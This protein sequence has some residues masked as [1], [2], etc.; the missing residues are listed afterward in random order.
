MWGLFDDREVR[1]GIEFD[2]WPPHL[3]E[4]LRPR[5]AF[6]AATYGAAEGPVQD[7]LVQEAQAMPGAS[8]L[9]PQDSRRLAGY[10]LAQALPGPAPGLLGGA[11]FGPQRADHFQDWPTGPYRRCQWN[12]L[13]LVV[14][15]GESECRI[16]DSA[17]SGDDALGE[18]LGR[19]LTECGWTGDDL[20]QATAGRAPLLT[21][22][23]VGG[24]LIKVHESGRAWLVELRS[25]GTCTE[26]PLDE[27]DGDTWAGEW[28]CDAY[29]QLVLAFGGYQL[30]VVGARDGLCPGL[31]LNAAAPDFAES[32]A[33]AR[34]RFIVGAIDEVGDS[35]RAVKW[36]GSKHVFRLTRAAG[37]SWSED[38]PLDESFLFSGAGWGST[39][40]WVV[41]RENANPAGFDLRVESDHG[42]DYWARLTAQRPDRALWRGTERWR[43]A[44]QEDEGEQA[45][46]IAAVRAWPV[47]GWFRHPD[48]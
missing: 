2:V 38:G 18:V 27:D 17:L 42:V 22:P 40:T 8:E 26:T 23:L 16:C 47:G 34:S 39:G 9:T 33:V 30:A 6:L 41:L 21:G 19:E 10:L 36:L 3:V 25:D 1:V 32:G 43:S 37:G 35:Q 7:R 13:H 24:E 14:S 29:G 45:V 44:K 31:E 28:G 4:A 20:R 11:E 12:P 15:T 48:R 46:V 5:A